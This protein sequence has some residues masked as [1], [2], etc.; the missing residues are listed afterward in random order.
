MMEASNCPVHDAR[1]PRLG[2][3]PNQETLKR[4]MSMTAIKAIMLGR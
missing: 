2:F 1:P 3:L 4:E